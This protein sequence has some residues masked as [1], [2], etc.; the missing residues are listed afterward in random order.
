METGGTSIEFDWEGT[1]AGTS[2]IVGT[3]TEETRTSDVSRDAE[4]RTVEIDGTVA[5]RGVRLVLSDGWETASVFRVGLCRLAV[6]CE[7]DTAG[8]EIEID[9]K[10][11]DADGE[12]NETD[13]GR[14]LGND[15]DVN[16]RLVAGTWTGGCDIKGIPVNTE[17]W[18]TLS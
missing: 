2:D 16:D 3:L 4:G 15:G 7:M 9:G 5:E 17:T 1:L 14:R 18:E 11:I 10:A 13:G 12:A 6:G 8:G